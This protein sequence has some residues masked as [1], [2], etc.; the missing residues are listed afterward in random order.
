MSGSSPGSPFPAPL[1]SSEPS[2]PGAPLMEP[3]RSSS[4]VL[5]EL[6][7]GVARAGMCAPNAMPGIDISGISCVT[8]NH[9][10][11]YLSRH[12]SERVESVSSNILLKPV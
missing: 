2:S 12:V 6:H 5:S 3:R 8:G 4:A 1:L 10:S 7:L 11:H 9:T